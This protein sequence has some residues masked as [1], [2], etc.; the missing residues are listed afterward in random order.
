MIWRPPICLTT[1]SWWK[2]STRFA[3]AACTIWGNFSSRSYSA[4]T[5]GFFGSEMSTMST[6]G[7]SSLSTITA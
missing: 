7:P 1:T 4:M 2:I 3:G 6:S 5:A